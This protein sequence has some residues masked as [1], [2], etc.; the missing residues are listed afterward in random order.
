MLFLDV[1]DLVLITQGNA[2]TPNNQW[3]TCS[4]KLQCGCHREGVVNKRQRRA[5][6][7]HSCARVLSNQGELM[8]FDLRLGIVGTHTAYNRKPGTLILCSSVTPCKHSLG[9]W[10]VQD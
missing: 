4:G 3:Q 7:V 9:I 2:F 5:M 10:R 6:R 1:R 8:G